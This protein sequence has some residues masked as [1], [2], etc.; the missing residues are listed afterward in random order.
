MLFET[1]L[2]YKLTWFVLP[3]VI[4][5]QLNVPNFMGIVCYYHKN[6]ADKAFSVKHHTFEVLNPLTTG[7]YRTEMFDKMMHYRVKIHYIFLNTMCL[8]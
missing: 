6:Y 7:N 1:V 8:H 4:P 3:F 5:L 2:F